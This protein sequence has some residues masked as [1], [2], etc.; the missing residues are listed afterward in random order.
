MDLSS[1]HVDDRSERA[2]HTK[3]TDQQVQATPEIF[4]GR[5]FAFFLLLMVFFVFVI[6]GWWESGVQ[7]FLCSNLLQDK[8]RKLAD[9][10]DCEEN[11]ST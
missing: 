3:L 5:E 10:T 11:F 1:W 8:H 6:R 4:K 2:Q 9:M 7:D